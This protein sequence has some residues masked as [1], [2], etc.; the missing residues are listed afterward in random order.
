MTNLIIFVPKHYSLLCRQNSL[1]QY[2]KSDAQWPR[3]DAASAAGRRK[4]RDSIAPSHFKNCREFTLQ[5][6]D[7]SVF[8]LQVRYRRRN[9]L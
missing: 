8:L 7:R 3:R 6:Y 4:R 5:R 9:R 2:S 1:V